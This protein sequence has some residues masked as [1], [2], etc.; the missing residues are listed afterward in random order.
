MVLLRTGGATSRVEEIE[1]MTN[2][3]AR[4]SNTNPLIATWTGPL[5]LPDFASIE[6]RDF[7]ATFAAALPAHLA[8]IETIAGNPDEPTFENTILALE[9][10]GELKNRAPSMFWNLTGANTNN[11]LQELERLLSPKFPRHNSAIVM[12]GALFA[13]IDAIRQVRIVEQTYYR[14]RLTSIAGI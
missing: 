6:D 9:L 4:K 10:A 8:E 1:E 5:G 14:W 7:E 12:N 11:T 13:R 3:E 2:E